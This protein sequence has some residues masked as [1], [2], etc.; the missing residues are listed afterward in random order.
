M[1]HAATAG[2]RRRRAA[3]AGGFAVVVAAAAGITA[4]AFA[5][6]ATLNDD[7][8]DGD[9]AGWS[10][11]GGSWSVVTDGNR[12]AR[13]ADTGSELAR[14]FAGDTGW[15]DYTLQARVRPVDLSAAGASAGVAARA[16]GAH[17]FERLVLAA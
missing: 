2:G 6:G 13:Q 3:L 1:K 17:R 10:K 9:T 12:V 11:S 8:E 7:F 5:A 14:L 16:S 15:T 4:T